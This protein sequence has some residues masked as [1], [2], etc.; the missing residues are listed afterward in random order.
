MPGPWNKKVVALTIHGL[1]RFACFRIRR[2]LRWAILFG[3]ICAGLAFCI[4]EIFLRFGENNQTRINL[5]ALFMCCTVSMIGKDAASTIDV[6]VKTLR[7]VAI[8]LPSMAFCMEP[9][10]L[11]RTMYFR[12]QQGKIDRRLCATPSACFR[13]FTGKEN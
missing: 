5:V 12:R 8:L 11:F 13:A 4:V 1:P 10:K 6:S 3:A 2:C 9:R 7:G